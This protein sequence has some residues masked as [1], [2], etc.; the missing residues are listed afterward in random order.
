MCTNVHDHAF[1]GSD[2][3]VYE[4]HQSLTSGVEY[5]VIVGAAAINDGNAPPV[6]ANASSVRT[7][8]PGTG[9]LHMFALMLS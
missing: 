5:D 8:I 4:T 1:S 3:Y 7:F 9:T 6:L 2:V